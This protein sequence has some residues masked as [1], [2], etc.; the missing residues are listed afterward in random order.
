MHKRT[1][2]K[3]SASAARRG[4][5]IEAVT[6]DNQLL[7]I[8][9]DFTADSGGLL[10]GSGR[11]ESFDPPAQRI[12]KPLVRDNGVQRQATWEEA[13]SL[14]VRRMQEGRVAGLIS[15]RLPTESLAAFTCLFHEVLTSGEVALVYG[16]CP[17]LDLGEPATL[18]DVPESDCIVIIGGDPLRQQKIVGYLAKRAYDNG[19]RLIV[20]DDTHSDLDPYADT[21]LH[22]QELSAHSDSPFA[23][24]R[25]TYHLRIS[26]LH[27]LKTAAEAAQRPLVLYGPGL[28]TTVYAA[29]RGLP[30]KVRF[31]PLVQG[32]NTCG[33]A[34]LGLSARAVEGGVLYALLGDDL[35]TEPPPKFDFT[36]VQAAYASPWTDAADVVLPARI[37]SEQSGH[38]TNLEGQMRHLH[39]LLS[40]PAA[41]RADGD[42]LLGLAM[43]MGCNLPLAEIPGVPRRRRIEGGIKV[44]DKP[45]IASDWLSGCAGCHMSLLD[46]DERIV[47][48][49][50]KA[51]LTSTPI[52]DLKH[53]SENGVDVGLLE[54]AV[55]NSANEEVATQMR[56][57]CRTLVALGDCAC[58]GGIPTLRNGATIASGSPAG[59]CRVGEHDGRPNPRRSGAGARAGRQG[60]GSGGGRGC[61]SPRMSALRR[62]HL[63]RG[64]R[65]SQRPQ[66]EIGG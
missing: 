22:L 41:V 66:A 33:A 58:F 37:W 56:R 48:L 18:Q 10:C 2:F 40:A 12:L 63:A 3:A 30:A 36:I 46:I 14:I 35:P 17:P 27:Q 32:T 16:D 38:I 21:H 26:G 34:K 25:I 47:T 43:R 51:M 13:M 53:P 44:S 45:T 9:G 24:L 6:R 7:R 64:D 55:T 60:A 42:V 39:P 59:L 50:E 5:G 49:L 31:L 1:A 8:D 11:F 61:V 62:R 20:V 23:R 28:S 19:A 29:L 4:A 15:P 52:T 54:G 57:R 65:A